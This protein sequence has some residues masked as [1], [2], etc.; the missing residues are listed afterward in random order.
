MRTLMKSDFDGINF[1]GGEPLLSFEKL[2]KLT[3]KFSDKSVRVYTNGKLLTVQKYSILVSSGVDQFE[4]GIHEEYRNHENQT[5][6]YLLKF[7]PKKF[8]IS[9]HDEF[10]K[11]I[12]EFICFCEE[13]GVQLNLWTMDDCENDDSE[14]FLI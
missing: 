9:I 12:P 4:I 3:K 6:R 10:A 11:T 14:R 8:R 7:N 1:T 2:T 13:N 5:L